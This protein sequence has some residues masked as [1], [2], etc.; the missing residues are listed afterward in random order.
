MPKRKV[1]EALSEE[2][3]SEYEASPEAGPSGS[4]RKRIAN[5]DATSARD[6]KASRK[7]A[8]MERNRQAAQI[9]RDRKKAHTEELE[10]K[11]S[12]LQS[13]IFELEQ[14]LARNKPA[15][16]VDDSRLSLLEQENSTLRTELAQEQTARNALQGRLDGLESQFTLLLSALQSRPVSSGASSPRSSVHDS[17]Q[18]PSISPK[19]LTLS[20]GPISCGQ[21][22]PFNTGSRLSTALTGPICQST[23]SLVAR[24]RTSL[25]RNL[26]LC[27][28]ASLK[29]TRPSFPP[30]PCNLEMRS[31]LLGKPFSLS[32][33]RNSTSTN[34]KASS[35]KNL[36][37]LSRTITRSL[38]SHRSLSRRYPAHQQRRNFKARLFLKTSTCPPP[39]QCKKD[40]DTDK[41]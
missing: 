26:V 10:V 3:G 22:A 32:T 17:G 37:H 25:Q 12:A 24:E 16:P 11:T 13:R 9:S 40:N 1:E 21:G 31:A 7:A 36:T 23:N 8:R 33:N 19:L 38:T 6:D 28:M 15:P 30:G 20:P 29:T 4:N 35:I 18:L 2:S 14:L 5:S 27:A 41:L 34:H 39:F